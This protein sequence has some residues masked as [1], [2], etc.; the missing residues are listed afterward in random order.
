MRLPPTTHTIKNQKMTDA[1]G[2]T[3]EA[4]EF[5]KFVTILILCFILFVLLPL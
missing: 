2:T 3:S 4:E 5:K 1:A